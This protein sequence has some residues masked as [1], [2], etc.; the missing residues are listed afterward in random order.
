MDPLCGLYCAVT[1]KDYQGRPQG[2]WFPEQRLSLQEALGLYTAA[3]ARALGLAGRAGV[4]APGMLAD[5]TVFDCDLHQLRDA[6]VEMTV[7][8]GQVRYQRA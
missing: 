8:D 6:R 5:F 3:G 1:R 4:L 7:M 2:G